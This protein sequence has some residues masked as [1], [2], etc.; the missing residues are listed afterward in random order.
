MS[1]KVVLGS[2]RESLSTN[3][4]LVQVHIRHV[5]SYYRWEIRMLPAIAAVGVGKAEDAMFLSPRVRLYLR[6]EE[7][8]PGRRRI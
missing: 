3:P 2:Q 1:R 7:R 8:M 6:H 5:D 4:L